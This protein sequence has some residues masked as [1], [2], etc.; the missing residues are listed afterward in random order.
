M[1]EREDLPSFEGKTEHL[2][3][4]RRLRNLYDSDKW[5]LGRWRR[6]K[7]RGHDPRYKDKR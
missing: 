5:E 4:S 2:I 1:E 3:R 6:T 7:G